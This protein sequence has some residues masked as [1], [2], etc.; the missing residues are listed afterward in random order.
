MDQTQENTIADG[1]MLTDVS[2]NVVQYLLHNQV[3]ACEGLEDTTLGT[4]LQFSIC[5]GEFA[6]ILFTGQCHWITVSNN[7]GC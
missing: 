5:G 4:Y 7:I 1:K 2:I 3:P 6:Q